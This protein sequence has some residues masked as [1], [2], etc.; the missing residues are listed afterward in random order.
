MNFQ[1]TSY[2]DTTFVVFLLCGYDRFP[3]ILQWLLHGHS[4][5]LLPS[6]Q[7]SNPAFYGS[8][9]ISSYCSLYTIFIVFSAMMTPSNGNIFR[10]TGPFWGEFAG[11]RWIRLTKLSDAELWCFFELH[12]NG[13]VYNREA[14]DLRRHRS[15]SDVTVMIKCK[16][17]CT[18]VCTVLHFE[19]NSLHAGR[20]LTMITFWASHLYPF[21][22]WNRNELYQISCSE[23][24][25]SLM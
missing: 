23:A 7:C 6:C 9:C 16:H 18:I 22:V 25:I 4:N 8:I 12:L 24:L 5:K 19:S 2:I 10:I 15:H 20:K 17:E 11:H 14:G 1:M 21:K 13:R 3:H